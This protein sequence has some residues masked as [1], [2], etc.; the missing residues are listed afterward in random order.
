MTKYT[1]PVEV[2]LWNRYCLSHTKQMLK[3]NAG[4]THR[5]D[6]WVRVASGEALVPARVD[7]CGAV[8]IAVAGASLVCGV[9]RRS[10]ARAALLTVLSS[11]HDVIALPSGVVRERPF[12]PSLAAAGLDNRGR[13]LDIAPAR[14]SSSS[15]SSRASVRSPCCLQRRGSGA[16]AFPHEEFA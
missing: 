3:P 4:K 1:R 15:S 13:D 9:G 6:F 16:R 5:E 8:P 2:E 14:G 10:A 11:R 7:R 12:H